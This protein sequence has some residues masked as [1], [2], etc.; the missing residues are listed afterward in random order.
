MEYPNSIT[1]IVEWCWG[2]SPMTVNEFT[3]SFQ[4]VFK[5]LEMLHHLQVESM[6][7]Q[8]TTMQTMLH[9]RWMR[10]ICSTVPPGGEANPLC[11]RLN[12]F[13]THQTWSEF[14]PAIQKWS[15]FHPAI[16]D[17]I[18]ISPSDPD[19]IGISPSDPEIKG[20]AELSTKIVSPTVWKVLNLVSSKE[21]SRWDITR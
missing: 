18:G 8:R 16:H 11:R 13:Q 10:T 6:S 21:S 7:T 20:A 19:M 15:E 9:A 1:L 3:S 14:H 5:R 2:T 17:M 12:C 4:I